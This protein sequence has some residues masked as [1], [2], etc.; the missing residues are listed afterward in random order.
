MT[1]PGGSTTILVVDDDADARL[2]LRVVLESRG[3]VV[4]EA[5]DG[6]AAL[7]TIR[8]RPDLDLVLLDLHMPGLGGREVLERL[9]RS[10][11]SAVPPV[12]VRSGSSGA[13]LEGELR[14]AGA[15][16]VVSKADPPRQLLEKVQALLRRTPPNSPV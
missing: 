13:E 14:A 8:A 7:E 11:A 10:G 1:A 3:I 12:V 9:A 2:L 6:E 4:V 16:D 15:A 5:S